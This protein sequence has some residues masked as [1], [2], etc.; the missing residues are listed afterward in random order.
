MSYS[1]LLIDASNIKS[2]GGFTHLYE[3]L[4][5]MNPDDLAF[6]E[7]SIIGGPQLDKIKIF[8]WIKVIQPSALMKGGF[9]RETIWK[10]FELPELARQFDLV[11]APGGTFYSKDVRYVSMSQNML[12]F[13]KEERRRYGFSW[14]WIRLKMLQYIQ[15]RSFRSAYGI[16]FISDFAK[17]YITSHIGLK[18]VRTVNIPHGISQRFSSAVKEQ[19]PIVEYSKER[20]F[21][22]LYVSIIDVYKHQDQV[23][24][25][26]VSLV[27]SGTPVCLDLVGGAY[28]PSLKALKVML[29]QYPHCIHY[30]GFQPYET[31]ERF[32]H[33]ADA[34]L[35]AS[36]CEN[37]P[38]ILIEAMASG[39]P[40]VA[41]DKGPMP[42]FLKDAGYYFDPLNVGSIG[43]AIMKM[44][45]DPVLRREK[46]VKAVEYAGKYSWVYC[47]QQT[48]QFLNQV[49]EIV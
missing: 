28:D 19:R 47:A 41:S 1:K 29:D 33:D 49:G 48:A 36:S 21:R 3:L 30:H 12:V 11:F 38:N 6:D 46:A 44:C 39:L 9:I 26:V 43:R 37:M 45:S 32:Y 15:E 8:D 10:I 22:L 16:I 7:V 35:F 20:P 24:R 14:I 40:I 18:N 13:Q 4:Y 17:K 34:F 23:I 5:N 27:E 25:A 42:E 31:I 2:G